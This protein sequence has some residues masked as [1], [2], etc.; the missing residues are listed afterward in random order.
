MYCKLLPSLVLLAVSYLVNAHYVFD[1]FYSEN[2]QEL[3]TNIRQPKAVDPLLDVNA[4]DM[5]CNINKGFASQTAT[6]PAGGMVGFELDTVIFHPG[7]ATFYLGK[8]PEGETAATWDGSG[9]QW[10]KIAEWGGK[11]DP[12]MWDFEPLNARKLNTTIPAGTPSGQ[13][14]L[15]VEQI[16]LLIPLEPQ[17]YISCAQIT[18]FDGG[19]GVPA[20][21]VAIP[22]HIQSDGGEH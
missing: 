13:Y 4:D 10:F 2:I 8:V 20:P 7:P 21:M 5:R 16:G 9:A 18:V 12:E 11:Y 14:L 3:K 1:K 6:I 17:F 19:N 15:R 22:G